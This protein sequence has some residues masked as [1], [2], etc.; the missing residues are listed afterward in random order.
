M[1][2]PRAKIQGDQVVRRAVVRYGVLKL[3]ENPIMR[4]CEPL[5]SKIVCY[6]DPNKDVFMVHGHR[7]EL[8]IQYIYF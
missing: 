6:W 8:T 1:D 7:I 4:A 5:L 3:V 2:A